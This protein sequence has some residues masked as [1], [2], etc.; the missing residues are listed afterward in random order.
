MLP[1]TIP[2]QAGQAGGGRALD[3]YW[4]EV[5]VETTVEGKASI[6]TQEYDSKNSP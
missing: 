5:W 6:G 4:S 2:G 3:I 1:E